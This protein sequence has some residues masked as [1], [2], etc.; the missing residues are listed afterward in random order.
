MTVIRL[1]KQ[2]ESK[3]GQGVF[4]I[5]YDTTAAIQVSMCQWVEKKKFLFLTGGQC[6]LIVQCNFSLWL[7]E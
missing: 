4:R 6:P 3:K 7:A 2:F 1:E 5:S